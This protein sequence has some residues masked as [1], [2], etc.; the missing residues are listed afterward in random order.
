MRRRYKRRKINKEEL[1]KKSEEVMKGLH[2]MAVGVMV[3]ET[4]RIGEPKNDFEKYIVDSTKAILDKKISSQKWV[5]SINRFV[6]KRIEEMSAD[7]PEHKEG[8]RI[9]LKNLK[10]INSGSKPSPYGSYFYCIAKNETG[11]KYYMTSSKFSNIEKGDSLTIEGMVKSNAEEIT[12]M[13]KIKILYIN[14][15]SEK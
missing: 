3:S 10:V 5:D 14:K 13:K 1:S 7:D 12:F 8:D 2:P 9:A 11:W 6:L 4:N 15:A